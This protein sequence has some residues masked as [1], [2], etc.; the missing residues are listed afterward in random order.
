VVV[1]GTSPCGDKTS[2]TV[3]LTVNETISVNTHPSAQTVCAGTDVTLSVSASSPGV[4]DF[5]YQW[6]RN[7]ADILNANAS[8]F[9]ITNAQPGNSG[10]YDVV[11]NGP[12]GYACGSV[13]SQV[14]ALV[15]NPLP[16]ATLSTSATSVCSG[17]DLSITLTGS[18]GIRPYTF[19]YTEEGI[20][21]TRTTTGA[22]DTVI[23][24]ITG[25]AP[26]DYDFVLNSVSDNAA[27]SNCIQNIIGQQVTITIKPI[28]D[29]TATPA[30]NAICS[31]DETSISLSG[32]LPGTVFSWTFTISGTV[33]GALAGNGNLIE[34]T[35]INNGNA[36][37]SVAYTI[38]PTLNGCIGTPQQ[39]TITVNP[40]P[41]ITADV[42]P[43]SICSFANITLNLTSTAAGTTFNWAANGT[44]VNIPVP[45]GS[46]TDNSLLHTV[47][48]PGPN[49]GT[50]SY[51]V[52]PVANGCTG[53]PVTT[54]VVTVFPLPSGNIE[55]D[56]SGTVIVCRNGAEPHVTFTGSNGTSPYEFTYLLTGQPGS[57]AV[58]T[59]AGNNVVS[60]NANTS[61]AGSFVYSLVG[62]KDVNT[63]GCPQAVDPPKT[64]TVIVRELPT[65]TISGNATVCINDVS[66]QVT[67]TGGNGTSPYTFNY[68]IN[69]VGQTPVTTISG[70]ALQL[71]VP[72]GTSGTFVYELTAVSENGSP[73]CGQPQ[74]GSVAIIVQ[75]DETISLKPG[76]NANQNICINN[77]IAPITFTLGGSADGASI[78][79]SMPAGL[80]TVYN[81][82][83]KEYTISGTPTVSGTFNFMVQ[84]TGPCDFDEFDVTLVVDPL[85]VG[86]SAA[87]SS[88]LFACAGSNGGKIGVGGYSGTI[89]GWQTSSDAG[90]TWTNVPGTAGLDTVTYSNLTQ[91]TW[92]RAV[93]TRS[94][95]TGV[96]AYSDHGFVSV[97]P[98]AGPGSLSGY[99]TPSVICSGSATLTAIGLGED[100]M[101]GFLSGGDFD[102]AGIEL[103]GPG[104]WRKMVDGVVKNIEA[105]TNNTQNSPFNLT[106]GGKTYLDGTPAAVY[107]DNSP[108]GGVPNNSKY[109][110]V[111]GPNTSTLETPIFNLIGLTEAEI[112]W[113]EAYI[114]GA[115]GSIRM[116]IS[117][118]GGITYDDLLRPDIIGPATNGVPNGG[119]VQTSVSL[120]DYLGMSNLRI[121]FTYTGTTESSWGLEGIEI[122]KGVP[123]GTFTWNLYDPIPTDPNN[124][125]GHFLNTLTSQSVVVTPPA[126][127]SDTVQV[128]KYSIVSSA[129]GCAADINVYVNPIPTVQAVAP[130]NAYCTGEALNI[131]LQ[132][133]VNGTKF[134]WWRNN[135]NISGLPMTDS[136]VYI[137]PINPAITG[138][139]VNNTL[140]PQSDIITV[141]PYY[142]FAGIT[143]AGTAIQIPYVVNPVP[144][145]TI[146]GAY[147]CP[148]NTTTVTV[149]VPV[150]GQFSGTLQPG[151]LAFSGTGPGTFSFDVMQPQN[152]T[153]NYYLSAFSVNGCA[154]SAPDTIEAQIMAAVGSGIPGLWTCATGDGDWFN[155]C[156]WANGKVPDITTNVVIPGDNG[157]CAAVIDPLNSPYFS[158]QPAQVNNITILNG[159]NLTMANSN[160]TLDVNGNWNNLV[161]TAG[162]T[163]GNGTV[164]FVGSNLQTI[165]TTGPTEN[166]HNLVVDKPSAGD[167]TN[168]LTLNSAVNVG[169]TLVL[170]SG[171]V[172]NRDTDNLLNITNCD[173]AAVQGGSENSYVNGQIRR[174]T[175]S[176]VVYT[177]PVGDPNRTGGAYRPAYVQPA[178]SGA[179]GYTSEYYYGDVP[180]QGTSVIGAE[181]I[182]IVDNEQWLVEGDNCSSE[183]S[184]G[185]DYI[186]NGTTWSPTAP[187]ESLYFWLQ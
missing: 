179:N 114:M 186:Y 58:T 167:H 144:T 48:A 156:N 166:F 106:N 43:T 131:P 16:N 39:E 158:D 149:T 26:G 123:G 31:G 84:T 75:P 173:E 67:L 68:S 168:G 74:T 150:T 19:T 22:F 88:N 95:C 78:A 56:I 63:S 27:G 66:P 129:G 54:D 164:A 34:Q 55:V 85:P 177:F 99:S 92:Y 159:G 169:G 82:V 115:G 134:V 62:V 90:Q 124:P 137:A 18:G 185:F 135:A 45:N 111:V 33:S 125:G 139:P 13:T 160:S 86:G 162:F 91:T 83:S 122:S 140:Q 64:A 104:K 8:T 141:I 107:Y 103:E 29:V 10:N 145:A 59:T 61:I 24:Q 174:C 113:W 80:S 25:Y 94:T 161:G 171:V 155:P 69:G 53:D 38:T 87:N 20:Q 2:N 21:K 28:P 44:N 73:N 183:A 142:T 138:N 181:I 49:D 51:T 98:S 1:R 100:S 182:G 6:R 178:G 126:N 157:E 77:P 60:V 117:T 170:N 109:M 35:L 116:E 152:T 110:M 175:N 4:A 30:A 42:S 147:D 5:T 118:D 11:I 187:E 121:R 17:E 15:V 105:S 151:N 52:T 89:A 65:A 71:P 36:P 165:T 127:T 180:E 120:N 40:I 72:T 41:V 146:T 101:V 153:V 50:V 3:T 148:S 32:T 70:N 112:T 9:E 76:S 133:T 176:T 14:A 12:V 79:G 172:N 93:I 96:V 119:F 23:I 37:G 102:N 108:L 163:A 130:P 132:G 7:G 128:Y 57:S 154:T 47:S 81:G 46:T 184:V 136:M 143:C 97:V